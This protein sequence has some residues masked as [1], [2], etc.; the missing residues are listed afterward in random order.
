MG[1]SS[2]LPFRLDHRVDRVG[3]ADVVARRG[4][5]RR[6][7]EREPVQRH[8]F[9]P[10]QPVGEAATHD[11]NIV[12]ALDYRRHSCGEIHDHGLQPPQDGGARAGRPPRR[13]RPPGVRPRHRC[14]KTPA[15][16]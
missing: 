16:W 2:R 12:G 3:R 15:A 11:D 1:T 10:G 14:S 13:R 5:P 4:V 8:D 6:L 7:V 9:V